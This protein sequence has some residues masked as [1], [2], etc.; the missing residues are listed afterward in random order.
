[1]KIKRNDINIIKPENQ[2]SLFGYDDYFGSWIRLFNNQKL[3]NC[4]LL[5]GP[6]GLGKATFVYHF[7]NFILSSGENNEYS[8]NKHVINKNNFSYNQIISNTHPNLF[9]I[10]N[11]KFSEQIKIEKVRNLLKFLSKSTLSKN[12][13]IV[14]IDNFEKFNLNSIN[15]LLKSIEEPSNNTFFFIIHDNSYKIT[16]TIK[17]R[18]MEFKI[19][20]SES[21][22]KHI[23]EKIIELYDDECKSFNVGNS[24]YFDTPGNLMKKIL[25]LNQS[26]TQIEQN[27]LTCIYF[28]LD[29]YLN[30]KNPLSLSFASFFIEKFYY[31]LCLNN[32]TNLNI[33]FMNYSKILRLISDMR[34]FNL[35]EK[36]TLISIKDI[37]HNEAR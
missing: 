33:H 35:F 5:S 31:E 21:Q 1:M 36:N 13:K 11:D 12:I 32:T 16:E 8:I 24:L 10:T 37:L 4:I 23:F 22:K 14:L 30:E 29:H 2:L 6:K 3:P 25:F 26:K 18:C 19:N 17:S 34:N 9:T 20:F 27:S 15:A 28:F 7:V